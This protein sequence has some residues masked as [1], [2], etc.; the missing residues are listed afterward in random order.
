MSVANKYPQN[1]ANSP[2]L[3]YVL[4]Q[5]YILGVSQRETVTTSHQ[6]TKEHNYTH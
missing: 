3:P 6:Q 5:E 4:Q 1:K 2:T